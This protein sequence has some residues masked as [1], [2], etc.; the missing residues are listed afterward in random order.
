MHKA[1]VI[2]IY[3]QGHYV[4]NAFAG[5]LT[6]KFFP[7]WF[8]DREPPLPLQPL[9]GV[10]SQFRIPVADVYFLEG[11]SCLVTGVIKKA[12]TGAKL[13]LRNGD[14][15]FHVLPNLPTYKRK[16]LEV[17]IRNIDGIISDSQLTREL[18]QKYT[19][20]PNEVGYP[21]AD[22]NK[23]LPIK[24][25]LNSHNAAYV[26]RLS[27]HKG[28]DLLINAFKLVKEKFPDFTLYLCGFFGK[29]KKLK[30]EIEGKEMVFPAPPIEIDMKLITTI[31]KT[32]GVRT[33]GFHPYPEKI[34]GKCSV[35][36]NAARIEPFGINVIEAMC[37]GLIPV[38]SRNV[39][40]KE[41]V[42]EL[43]PSLVVDLNSA[44]IAEKVIE[45]FEMPHHKKLKLS[46]RAKEIGSRF[47]KERAL[48]DFEYKFWKVVRAA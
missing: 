17:L 15:L 21:Y 16:I 32:R 5:T 23:F 36:V 38:V 8:L 4:N 1:K 31:K 26:G 20:V 44:K 28:A 40:T 10:V 11:G 45:I 30:V 6:N 13:V 3:H 33:L 48:K 47:T 14:P 7:C 34:M 35:Y 29:E 39:G 19:K 27:K 41:V 24:P 18:A 22:V 12:L 25:N 9:Y 43:D 2:Y 37:A 42:R 46:E